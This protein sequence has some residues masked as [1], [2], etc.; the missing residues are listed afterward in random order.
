MRTLLLISLL[1]LSFAAEVG[2]ED[3]VYVLTDDNFDDFIKEHDH[4]LVKFYAPWCGHC[5]K[6]APEYSKAAVTLEKENLFLAQVDAT[7]QNK[8]A[9]K[10]QIQGYP[11]IK[12]FSLGSEVEYNGGR[13]E[14]DIVAWMRKKTGPA[15]S[16]FTKEEEIEKFKQ[17]NEV[18]LVYFGDKAE[19]KAAFEKV[20]KQNDE[21]LFAVCNE[22]SLFKKYNVE[23][24]T[25]VLFKKFD[26][27]RNDLTKDLTESNIEAF[28]KKNATPL[29][30]PFDQKTAQLIFGS[31]QP[32]LVLYRS[33][34]DAKTAALDAIMGEVAVEVKGKLQVV[35]TDIKEGFEARLAEFIGVKK[36]DLPTVR[37][38][39]T[40]SDMKK[41]NM[42]GEITKEN[43][44]D[45]VKK[46]EEG[47]LKPHLKSQEI[48]KEQKGD[49]YTLVGKAFEE[50]VKTSDKDVLVKFYAPWCGHCKSLAPIYEELAKKLKHNEKL[51]IAEMDATENEVE[52]VQIQGFPTIK[53]WP[54][55]KK[56][57]PIEFD[58]ERTVDAFVAFLK[59]HATN[60]I[61]LEEKKEEA[62]EKKETDL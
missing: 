7:V 23:P 38:S 14:R 40:R 13:E 3:N 32:G 44:L 4:V 27:K 60:K 26:D 47:K 22:Q 30:M 5:K 19:N 45:F 53:F 56:D 16:V 1:A 46:W 21:I 34:D 55:G 59:Q 36:E 50:V 58:G 61:E 41:Y 33:K 49:V 52:E 31:N 37:I 15:T 10:Y 28:I 29:V 8:L 2:K 12:L 39:D 6:L 57:K 51:V 11:T 35:A 25:I 54:A 43:V 24:E 48:P 20:A 62:G 17:D 42:E 18:A 9:D